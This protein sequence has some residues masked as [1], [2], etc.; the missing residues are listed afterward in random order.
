MV[1]YNGLLKYKEGEE[2][3]IYLND[4][5][6]RTDGRYGLIS[7]IID[8]DTSEYLLISNKGIYEYHENGVFELLY[9]CQ[10]EILPIK[11]KDNAKILQTGE[12]DFIDNGQY[13][14]LNVADK[15]YQVVEK[16][17]DEGIID[18]LECNENGNYF[19]MISKENLLLKYVRTIDGLE[20]VDQ[21]G[22]NTPAHTIMDFNDL[23]FIS[24]NDGLSIYSKSKHKIAQDV[25]VDEFN[26]GAI[27]KSEQEVKIGSIHGVY[28]FDNLKLL[29][30]NLL[31]SDV[32]S[33]P[34]TFLAVVIISFAVIGFIVFRVNRRW[35]NKLISD[36]LN[37]S[38]IKRF[39]RNNLAVV[40]LSLIEDEFKLD[41][42]ELNRLSHNFKPAHYI[43]QQRGIVA[44]EM[45]LADKSISVISQKTGYSESY[46]I[47]NK[48]RFL[49]K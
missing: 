41:Y 20:L 39:I 17:L 4:N 32:E 48:K 11:I 5:S 16:D 26:K 46:L 13:I 35:K 38:L 23:V 25:V 43:R 22:L 34:N 18:A 36:E 6:K 7:D 19:Y 1:C 30:K 45:F 28:T 44:K 3:I 29:E 10:K 9:S 14:S 33:N 24:G 42:N 21:I 37:I 47:K 15:S 40:T 8:V 27:F 12:F 2:T 31:Y 49:K